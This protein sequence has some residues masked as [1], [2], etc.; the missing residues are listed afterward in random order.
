M[1]EKPTLSTTQ[2]QILRD[3]VIDADHPGPVLRDFQ[4]LL[5][6]VGTQG[7]K[8]G[9]KYNLLP[10][11]AIGDLD[12]RLS[13]PLRLPLKRP[14][15]RSHP[16]LQG[17]HLLF[18]A[19]GLSRIEG[20]GEKARLAVD[21]AVFER[22]NRLNPT[23]QYFTLLEAWLR[24][25]RPEM[26]GG[27]GSGFG[28]LRLPC[29][30]TWREIP[31]RGQRFDLRQ[32]QDAYLLGIGREFYQLALMDLFGLLE[33]EHPH[34]PL[35]PWCPAAVRHS[36]FGDALFTLLLHWLWPPWRDEGQGGD[37]Q[38]EDEPAAVLRF[39]RWQPFFQPYFPEWRENLVLPEAKAR[40]GVF[41]FRV[42]LGQVWRRIAMPA[43][44]TLEDLVSW[45]LRSVRFDS[46]HLY[47]FAYRDRF[48]AMVRVEHPDSGE[49][50]WTDEVGVGELPLEP[51]QSMTFTY[52][53]GDNWQFD[54]K[55]ERIEPPGA[56]IKAPRILEKHG[57]AP[58]QYPDWG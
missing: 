14:Q 24:V 13:R 28:G 19:S 6:F 15:L 42:S 8:A 22:W 9:G 48:G 4:T 3:Q 58:E 36:P 30:Q 40:G 39:G 45:I 32:A 35:Q 12:Q 7:V 33:V 54:V 23:E 52:D 49:G 11:G 53:F 41:V 5:D 50:P 56:R 57:K 1:I 51:G 47:E 25:G 46:D 44:S 21:P 29:L 26:V 34:Q 20:T 18:R 27:R 37:D 38:D 55:L 2:E 16:Y 17:L 43:D 10:I 31:A